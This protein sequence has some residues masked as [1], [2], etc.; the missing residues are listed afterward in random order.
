MLANRSWDDWISQ[1]EG[2]HQNSVNRACHLVG[3]PTIALSLALLPGVLFS[4]KWWR[5]PA[6]LF[7][8]GWALQFI[9]HAAEGKKPEFFNDYRFLFV[10]ARWWMSALS[11]ALEPRNA[12]RR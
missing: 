12:L 1:Y 9:G 7:I 6:G 11:H 4:R 8:A 3:I 10:G 2:S 5:V